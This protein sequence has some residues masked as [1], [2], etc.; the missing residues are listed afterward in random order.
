ME[1]KLANG[2]VIKAPTYEEALKVAVKM[3]E[4]TQAAL[5]KER[6]EWTQKSSELETRVN[7]LAAQIPKPKVEPTNG[8]DNQRYWTLLN[9]DPIAAQ[10][11]MDAHRFGIPDP[12]QV[13]E[14]F[15]TMDKK[16][17]NFEQTMLASQFIYQH[18]EFPATPENAAIVTRQVEELVKAG[19]PASI[20]TMNMAWN[21]IVE[22]G[23][24]KPLETKPDENEDANPSL[25]GSGASTEI[26]PDDKFAAMSTQEMEAYLKSQGRL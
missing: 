22:S 10:N 18:E 9:Q 6:E 5:K 16:I 8:F 23:K 26:L 21:Q 20:E 12:A 24:I 17:N 14:Y 11:Y 19:H 3:T 15:Q 13:P 25:G 7:E 1:L 4:D 2:N